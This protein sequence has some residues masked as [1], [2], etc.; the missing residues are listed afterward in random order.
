LAL[1]RSLG[2]SAAQ[3][4]DRRANRVRAARDK[5]GQCNRRQY[6][7][8][9]LDAVT[10]KAKNAAHGFNDID[11]LS[12]RPAGDKKSPGL[13]INTS[14]SSVAPTTTYNAKRLIPLNRKRPE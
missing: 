8:T 6:V 2:L 14:L 7:R 11:F 13:T 5:L 1:H 10:G 12:G 4:A 3:R 9:R